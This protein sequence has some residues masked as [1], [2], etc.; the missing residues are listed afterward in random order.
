VRRAEAWWAELPPPFG[1][2]PVVV[3]SRDEACRCREQVL[4]AMVTT[5]VRRIPTEVDVGA[6]EGLA[7]PSVVNADVLLTV[8]RN[9]LRRRLG[10]L[11]AEKVRRLDRALAF[12]LG[13]RLPA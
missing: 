6:A 2:R 11:G 5:R 8:S 13:L 4:V 10:T 9:L 12:A 7:K 1:A 3:V